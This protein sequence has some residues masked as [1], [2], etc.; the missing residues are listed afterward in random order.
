MSSIVL[1]QC[2]MKHN[3]NR[4]YRRNSEDVVIGTI[5][6][7]RSPIFGCNY[8]EAERELSPTKIGEVDSD[9]YDIDTIK[10][11][12]SNLNL[13][14]SVIVQGAPVN[15]TAANI[16]ATVKKAK[17]KLVKFHV[18]NGDMLD[19]INNSKT[20]RKQ[21]K[22]WGK[23]AR[24]V[25][26]IFVV[27]EAKLSEKF[28]NKFNLD[29]SIGVK[30]MEIEIGGSTSSDKMTTIT[31]SEGTCFAYSLLKVKWNKKKTEVID[32]DDDPW[33]IG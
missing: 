17:L 2:F 27:M 8:I 5:G 28:N 21:L 19:A 23:K 1:K 30:G 20:R 7:K 9:V 32:L 6:E 12:G 29:L 22:L 14:L 10:T 3:A 11:K 13:N 31:L 33:G 26:E 15:L 18:N 25:H 4:Y 24:V 16:N